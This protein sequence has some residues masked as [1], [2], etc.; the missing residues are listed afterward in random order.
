MQKQQGFTLIELV[1]VIII[2][3]VLAVTAAPKFINLQSDAR[4]S[5]L[6]GLKGA[7]NGSNALI[8]SK[9]VLESK[10]KAESETLSINGSSGVEDD[11][12][13]KYGY[14][15]ANLTAFNNGMDASFEAGTSPS[16]SGSSDWV[17]NVDSSGTSITFWQ[18]GAPADTSGGSTACKI[19]YTPAASDGALPSVVITDNGC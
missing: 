1:V 18:R 16:D 11:V 7:I 19:V 17:A 4:M 13:I 10:Q 14:M 2:L 9:A 15:D 12:A 5:A 6:Q 8:F 3:G